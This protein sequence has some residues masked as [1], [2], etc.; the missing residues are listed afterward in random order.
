MMFILSTQAIA[1]FQ[2][3]CLMPHGAIPT[4]YPIDV[5]SQSLQHLWSMKHFWGVWLIFDEAPSHEIQTLP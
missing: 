5:P 1:A 2:G 4:N 3:E